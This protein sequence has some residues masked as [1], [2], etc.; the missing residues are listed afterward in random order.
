[1]SSINSQRQRTEVKTLRLVLPV[2]E[3]AGVQLARETRAQLVPARAGLVRA[4][5]MLVRAVVLAAV[6]VVVPALAIAM[7]S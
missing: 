2:S 1:M 5:V 3:M 6:P 4:P 7:R